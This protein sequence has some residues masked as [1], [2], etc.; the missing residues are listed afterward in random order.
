MDIKFRNRTATLNTIDHSKITSIVNNVSKQKE[1]Q[2]KKYLNDTQIN[3]YLRDIAQSIKV[4]ANEHIYKTTIEL[5]MEQYETIMKPI[6]RQ[7]MRSDVML[8]LK[9]ELEENVRTEL[10]HIL[11][12]SVTAQLRTE[13]QSNIA[14]T[15]K[16]ELKQKVTQELKEEIKPAI[17]K[18]LKS[19]LYDST[20]IELK[21]ELKPEIAQE[22][23]VELRQVVIDE[24]KIDMKSKVI[25]DLKYELKPTIEH[26]LRTQCMSNMSGDSNMKNTKNQVTLQNNDINFNPYIMK[27][28]VSHKL[29]NSEGS[30]TNTTTS[31]T[32]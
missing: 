11:L 29:L 21:H 25:Q 13:L 16:H 12:S 23:R 20:A 22:L 31:S 19:E 15:L 27:N 6:M 9:Q 10:K 14:E 30:V 2:L 3:D 18:Q 5:L 1:N 17:I 24:L 7:E 4:D 8:L 28:L 26:E 32:L